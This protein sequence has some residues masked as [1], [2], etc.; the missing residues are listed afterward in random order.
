MSYLKSLF[1]LQKNEKKS[2]EKYIHIWFN[3]NNGKL[4]VLRK[5]GKLF[6]LIAEVSGALSARKGKMET[7][8]GESRM[9]WVKVCI[10]GTFVNANK[11]TY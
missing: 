3:K 5:C 7:Q 9:Y 11:L 10:Q 8:D 1:L 2:E 4:T 6:A